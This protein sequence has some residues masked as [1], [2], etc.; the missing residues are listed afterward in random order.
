MK[1][2]MFTRSFDNCV[3]SC[4]VDDAAKYNRLLQYCCGKAL[5]VIECCAVM[6]P[7]EGYQKARQLLRNRFGNEYVIAEAWVKKL[8][9]GPGLRS[10]DRVG[11]Q[12]LADDLRSCKETLQ[13]R[14]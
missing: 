2:W 6:D 8:V 13:A 7:R 4:D 14:P 12:E 1:F 11:L 5:K 3:D 9:D 10:H